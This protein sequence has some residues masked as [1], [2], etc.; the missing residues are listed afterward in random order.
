[1]KW[2]VFSLCTCFVLV[3][4]SIAW[5]AHGDDPVEKPTKSEPTKSEP[6]K[7]E[8][9]KSEKPNLDPPR[10][11]DIPSV[12]PGDGRSERP[13]KPDPPKADKPG[14]IHSEGHGWGSV[15]TGKS[16]EPSG[17]SKDSV[18][19]VGVTVHFLTLPPAAK[20]YIDLPSLR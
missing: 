17:F 4:G 15:S 11:P 8:P 6:T 19:G 20:T 3:A 18:I 7:S 2:F 13:D 16:V 1:M 10:Q 12:R 14:S 5:A 9:T